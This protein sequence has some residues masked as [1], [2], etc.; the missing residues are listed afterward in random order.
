MRYNG[1]SALSAVVILS[2]VHDI[3]TGQTRHALA[4]RGNALLVDL[5]WCFTVILYSCVSLWRSRVFR[6]PRRLLLR[7]S[8]RMRTLGALLVSY[9]GP[10]P[11]G[12]K[13]MDRHLH[14]SISKRA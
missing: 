14:P 13:V 4:V 3:C 8:G 1:R 9:G 12:Q 2:K 7:Q 11:L 5:L 6:L 10:S